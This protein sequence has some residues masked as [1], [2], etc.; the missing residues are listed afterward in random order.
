[1]SS[2]SADDV[3]TSPAELFA[4]ANAIPSIAAAI[5]VMTRAGVPNTSEPRQTDNY[6]AAFSIAPPSVL[7]TVVKIISSESSLTEFKKN[8]TARW[9]GA[10]KKFEMG[11]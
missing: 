11:S 8:A 2:P 5:I 4:A 3:V 9:G 10:Q 1:M 6:A 7:A